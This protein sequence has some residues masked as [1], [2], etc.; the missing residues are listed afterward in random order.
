[1]DLNT[2]WTLNYGNDGEIINQNDQVKIF[3]DNGEILIGEYENSDWT[4]L[5]IERENC[6]EIIIDFED[7]ESIQVLNS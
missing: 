5:T 7:I 1:M 6:E 2:I 4:S 3:L